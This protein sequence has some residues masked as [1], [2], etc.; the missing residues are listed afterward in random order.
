MSNRFFRH[1]SHGSVWR[2]AG[3]MIL[4]NLTVP[5]LGIVDTAVVGHLDESHHMGAVAIGSAIFGIVFWGFG[6]LRMG[7]TGITAQAYG[8]NDN[9]EL[10]ATLARALLIAAGISFFI[11][12]LQSPVAW[13]AFRVI[14]G[15][16]LVEQHG[17]FYFDIR[18]WSAPATFMNYALLGWF[19]GMQNAR[20]PLFILTF[21]NL[22][23]MLLDVLFVMGLGYGASGVAWASL[24]AE[25]AGL[26][27]ALMLA[28][29]QLKL[30]P[31]EAKGN[32][33]LDKRKIRKMLSINKD[34]FIR[35]LYSD[36]SRNNNCYQNPANRNLAKCAHEYS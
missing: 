9:N 12:L 13:L 6:F 4:S 21:V 32:T 25:Y 2:I 11:I 17:R 26:G 22:I 24:L 20:A 19:L 29:K 30:H 1:G 36:D 16:E 27:F 10:R 15:S 8:E 35:N 3:P 31:G 14:Q 7:T 5:L 33:I 23:N 28:A 34:I 18:I